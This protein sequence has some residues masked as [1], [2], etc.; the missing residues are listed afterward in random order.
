MSS[1]DLPLTHEWLS[2]VESEPIPEAWVPGATKGER[3]SLRGL[4]QLAGALL[5]DED[6]SDLPSDVQEWMTG[7]DG[8]PADAVAELSAALKKEPDA[9]LAG[10][11]A[12]L[13]R[14][15]NRRRLG[16]FFSAER[17][18]HAMLAR[19]TMT[20]PPPAH[21]VDVGAG[22]GI[23][24]AAAAKRWQGAA[25][26]AVDVNPVTLGLLAVRLSAGSDGDHA[27]G[28]D[29][30]RLI[31][32]D[33][34]QW[35]EQEWPQLSGPKLILGNPPYTRANLLTSAERD[36]LLDATD[37]M[38]NRQ[39]NLSAVMTAVS[40]A[41]LGPDDGLCLLLPAQWLEARY[42][43]TLRARLW[44]MRER[45]VELG[46]F[47]SGLF[48]EAQVDAVMLI[49]GREGRRPGFF[50]G[51]EP[52]ED[53]RELD[54]SGEAPEN[55]RREL[56]GHTAD[57]EASDDAVPLSTLA[58]VRRGTATGANDFFTLV[59]EDAEPIKKH[60]V[61]LLRHPGGVGDVLDE[62]TF[63]ASLKGSRRWL[64]L[65]TESAVESDPVLRD[66]IESGKSQGY[67]DRLLCRRRTA[68]WYDLHHDL[69]RPDVI[70]GSMS[71]GSFAVIEN[72]CCAAITNNMYGLTWYPLVEQPVRTRVLNWLRASGQAAITA[73][74]R[75]Q[76][77][78]LRKIEPRALAAIEVPLSV[79][80]GTVRQAAADP[81]RAR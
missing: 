36:S 76:G 48:R 19:W 42:A 74:A 21:I 11:Y 78:N 50:V 17:E 56:E 69:V 35:I 43:E 2:R 58:T 57:P 45:R 33:F 61:R 67:A 66:L 12:G 38:L 10:L 5:D 60:C 39:A 13:V 26:H 64:L 25:V 27:P 79:I 20:Q 1:D 52:F 55:W 51:S 62:A 72:A 8:V 65:A 77:D 28:S 14:S 34:V 80:N 68:G 22:V 73:G 54:R 63:D 49:V 24:T 29:R 37:G 59:D 3:R 40:I 16:T 46:L 44:A 4:G 23:F 71:K 75:H 47:E 81:A 32:Q 9:V 53:W 41:R 18:V 7:N 6:R 30:V 15:S 70:I 31:R